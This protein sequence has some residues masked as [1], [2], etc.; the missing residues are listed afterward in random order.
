MMRKLM[1]RQSASVLPVIQTSRNADKE[2]KRRYINRHK[3]NED[4]ANPMTA[5]F[6]A[7]R[8]LWNLHSVKASV[9]GVNKRFKH[10]HLKLK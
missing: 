10:I 5:G 6:Y 2:R 3:K 4:W 8:I 7:K 1:A 9:V